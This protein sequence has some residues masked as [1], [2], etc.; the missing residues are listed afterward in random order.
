MCMTNYAL[1]QFQYPI[2][3]YHDLLWFFFLH[4][5]VMKHYDF[6]GIFVIQSQLNSAICDFLDCIL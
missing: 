6:A 3:K 2:R 5:Y 1:E 4:V